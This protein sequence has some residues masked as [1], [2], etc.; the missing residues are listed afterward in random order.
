MAIIVKNYASSSS[1]HGIPRVALS[2]SGPARVTWATICLVALV[3]FCVQ[4]GILLCKYFT[5]PTLTEVVVTTQALPFPAVTICSLRPAD[6]YTAYHVLKETQESGVGSMSTPVTQQPDVD[7]DDRRIE[8][9]KNKFLSLRH[10]MNRYVCHAKAYTDYLESF[11]TTSYEHCVNSNYETSPPSQTST[12]T[13]NIPLGDRKDTS[14]LSD[15]DNVDYS[16][17]SDIIGHRS[18][19]FAN[20]DLNAMEQIGLQKQELIPYCTYAG[21]S[22]FID[23]FTQFVDTTYLN[24]FTFDPSVRGSDELTIQE[25]PDSGLVIGLFVPGVEALNASA[26]IL[27]D[28]ALNHDPSSGSEGVRVSIHAPGSKVNPLSEGIDVPRGVSASFGV[29]M[30]EQTRAKAPHGNCTEQKFLSEGKMTYGYS[31]SECKRMCQQK[32]IVETCGCSDISL[33]VIET[34][35]TGKPKLCAEFDEL[36]ADCLKMN[37]LS[38]NDIADCNLLMKSWFRR[39]NCMHKTRANVSTNLS[40]LQTCG[41]QSRCHEVK[42][43]I[44]YSLSD[45]PL[46]ENAPKLIKKLLSDFAEKFPLEK[47]EHYFGAV[48]RENVTTEE[49]SNFVSRKDFLK[50]NVYIRDTV[51]V[52]VVERAAYDFTQL[53]SELGGQLSLWIGVSIITI[54]EAMELLLRLVKHTTNRRKADNI[55]PSKGECIQRFGHFWKIGVNKKKSNVI[56]VISGS[57]YKSGD[58]HV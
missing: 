36:P 28:F 4:G 29:H 22:C 30:T 39:V 38:D 25:G 7:I 15:D 14:G 23:N 1:A 34:C 19:V 35:N 10:S 13:D 26:D 57:Q 53:V 11:C 32:L 40:A 8:L 54:M 51:V 33:P 47:A 31:I 41:C 44:E 20:M 21:K 17:L 55:V 43:D 37:E 48:N 50:L 46:P 45:W 42:Y 56:K 16:R 5:Y 6:L 9:E 3:M 49:Y 12:T 24:C 58:S 27:S 18:T 52:H 2:Q